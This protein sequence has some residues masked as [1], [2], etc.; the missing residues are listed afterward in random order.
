MHHDGVE[1]ASVALDREA[2]VLVDASVLHQHVGSRDA[3]VIKGA[4]AVVLR[5]VAHLGAHVTALD[6]LEWHEVLRRPDL[7]KEREHAVLF[8][9]YEKLSKHN[10]VRAEVA[11]VAGPPLGRAD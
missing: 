6:A 1:S 10:S 5:V 2:A 9:I 7:H 11:E 4:P 8:P 3:Y